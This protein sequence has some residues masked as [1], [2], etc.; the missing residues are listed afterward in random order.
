[1]AAGVDVAAAETLDHA[2]D[3]GFPALVEY[4][5]IGF[6]F[7]LAETVHAAH[8]V[9][10]VHEA[11]VEVSHTPPG[12]GKRQSAADGGEATTSSPRIVMGTGI[13]N[14]PNGGPATHSPV[15]GR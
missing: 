11:T 10:A 3:P 4:G 8:V 2:E 14:C 12:C 15:S 6:D 5:F 1:M 13:R 7:D 9:D